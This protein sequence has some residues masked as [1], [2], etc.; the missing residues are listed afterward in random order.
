MGDGVGWAKGRRFCA[1]CL[2]LINTPERAASI[3]EF[4]FLNHSDWTGKSLEFHFCV[5]NP[6]NA[7]KRLSLSGGAELQL[8]KGEKDQSKTRE[9]A[10]DRV[11]K[12]IIERFSCA[13]LRPFLKRRCYWELS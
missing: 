11:G 3:A 13:I 1:L 10:S 2:L 8:Q 7:L 9:K 5:H 12:E 6:A 4:F